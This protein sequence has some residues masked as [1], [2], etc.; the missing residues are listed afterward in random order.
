[1]KTI[2]LI[3]SCLLLLSCTTEKRKVTT[4]HSPYDTVYV[5]AKDETGQ[6]IYNVISEKAVTANGDSL[7]GKIRKEVPKQLNDKEF[8]AAKSVVRKYIHRHQDEFLPFEFYFQ[9]YLGYKKEGVLMADVA[10]FSY[11]NVIY[12][13]GVAGI[14][15]EDYRVKFRFLKD[16]GKERKML[17]IN[18]DK[19]VV[20]N[21]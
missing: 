19:G 13:K 5:Y 15:R 6:K 17:T 14:T 9:Q 11:Y 12:Q 16:L 18:L 2:L 8:E 10:L 7:F 1:M 4:V 20:V 3:F 21:E